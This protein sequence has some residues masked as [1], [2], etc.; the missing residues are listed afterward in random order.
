MKPLL[1]ASALALAALGA[2]PATTAVQKKASAPRDWTKT[3]VATPE[4]GFRVGNPQARTKL[5]EYGSLT[6]NHC[7]LFAKEG[8]PKLLSQYVKSGRLSFEFRNFVR[9]PYDLTGALLSRCAGPA[10]FFALTDGIFSTQAQWLERG[11]AQAST[12]AAIPE[13]QQF[14]KIASVTGLN[15]LAAKAG[16]SPARAKQCL[17]DPKGIE[18]LVQMRGV[19]I[20]THGLEGTPTFVLNGKTVNATD[21]SELKPL[22]GSPGG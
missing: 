18:K 6:C 11:K 8:T 16:V 7:A 12:I 9:D 14:A 22:L 3:V 10:N 17:N 4:G 5:I 19:A 21:W 20:D 1:L 2:G 15:T 13:A